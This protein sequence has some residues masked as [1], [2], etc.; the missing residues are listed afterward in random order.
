MGG[1]RTA[2]TCLLAACQG[3]ACQDAAACIHSRNLCLGPGVLRVRVT[4]H[5]GPWS[6]FRGL[7]QLLCSCEACLQ[8]AG[9]DQGS[10]YGATCCSTRLSFSQ[11]GTTGGWCGELAQAGL[12]EACRP[13]ACTSHQVCSGVLQMPAQGHARDWAHQA[14]VQSWPWPCS[15]W[16]TAADTVQAPSLDTRWVQCGCHVG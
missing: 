10:S 5:C 13:S 12:G 9:P 4:P 14:C 16:A 1:C 15:T 2:C 8:P 11:A 7:L 3:E 6:C